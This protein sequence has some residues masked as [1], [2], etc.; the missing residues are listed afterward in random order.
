MRPF[1]TDRPRWLRR[2]GVAPRLAMRMAA[3]GA[4]SRS[5]LFGPLS[6][7]D[8]LLCTAVLREA[9]L[10]N[11]PFAMFS[12][13]P[14]LFADNR[15]PLALHPIDDHYIALL[16]RLGRTVV[17][18]YYSSRDPSNPD[19][20][21]TPPRHIIAEMCRLAGL[22]GEV[23]LRPYL[24]LTPEELAA[25]P[26]LPRQI[27]IHSSAAAA[28]IPY[29]N[30]EW[31]TDR[32]TDISRLLSNEFSLVQI[33]SARDP[34]IPGVALDLRG[35]TTLREAAA[36]QAA[37]LIFIGLEGFLAHLARAVDCPSVVIQGG[38]TTA[39][40]FGYSANIHLGVQMDCSPCGLRKDCP[41]QLAC[42]RDLS[43]DVVAD[44]ARSLAARQRH[45]LPVDTAQI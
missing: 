10:R 5:L 14:E 44:A 33:G 3:W 29:P 17:T 8:D 34:A 45:P 22:R 16:R 4:P 11:T 31:G 28:A 36:I 12:N 24:H 26:H 41:F 25:A 15:D 35:R 23:S 1:A 37:S 7:G 39:A 32:F 2:L 9:R 19:R 40:Q 38:R 13:R 43:P 18:P 42:L 27:A 6:I 20:E 30:K 21:I